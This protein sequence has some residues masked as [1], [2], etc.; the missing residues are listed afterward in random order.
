M[1]DNTT[2]P[3]KKDSIEI[4][5]RDGVLFVRVKVQPKASAAA[6]VGEHGGALKIRVAAAPENGKANRAVVEFMAKKL[7][8][9][10][11]DV[12]IISGEHSRDKLIAI[13]GLKREELLG[14]L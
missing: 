14:L 5:E 3:G 7:R 8:L 12:S 2:Q 9:K 4:S 13:R 10:K 1:T 11:S 6:I